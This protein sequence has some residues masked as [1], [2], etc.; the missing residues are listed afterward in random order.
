MT[1][2]YIH[3]IIILLRETALTIKMRNE[4]N[5]Q[6]HVPNPSSINGR[7]YPDHSM[8]DLN[9]E[10]ASE[11][12]FDPTFTTTTMNSEIM[13]IPWA[14]SFPI[15]DNRSRSQS[16]NHESEFGNNMAVA[17]ELALLSEIQIENEMRKK[18]QMEEEDADLAFALQQQIQYD[19]EFQS[20]RETQSVISNC[21][22][23][24]PRTENFIRTNHLGC[25][26]DIEISA[27]PFSSNSNA[28]EHTIYP[29]NNHLHN[30]NNQIN[31]DTD[32]AI[33]TNAD[34]VAA[35]PNRNNSILH[36]I[37]LADEEYARSL[38]RMEEERATQRLVRDQ[39]RL[40]ASRQ[41]HRSGYKSCISWFVAGAI[42]ISSI[43]TILYFFTPYLKGGPFDLFGGKDGPFNNSTNGGFGW[44]DDW[45]EG[46]PRKWNV[47][48][49]SSL[50]HNGKQRKGLELTILNAC[51]EDWDSYLTKAVDDW[52]LSASLDLNLKAVD[53][54]SSCVGVRGKIKVCNGDYGL[55][56]WVGV[57]E[58][59][60]E[61]GYIV[62]STA[63]M[64][65]RYMSSA[66]KAKK[67]YTMCHEIGHGLGLPHTDENFLNRD[68][69]N[70]LDY[71]NSPENNLEPGEVNFLT[72]L[73]MYGTVP[74]KISEYSTQQ[75]TSTQVVDVWIEGNIKLWKH[76]KNGLNLLVINALSPE[77]SRFFDDVLDDWNQAPAL[78][79]THISIPPDTNCSPVYESMKVCNGDYGPTEWL[80]INE[81]ILENDMI[82]MSTIKMNDFHLKEES[83]DKKQYS[84]CHEF[85]HGFGLTHTD[86][87]YSNPN[88]GNCLDYTND[89]KQNLLSGKLNW[90]RLEKL[91]G[92]P[93]DA[94]NRNKTDEVMK[95]D[96]SDRR[97]LRPWDKSNTLGLNS[98]P[99][100]EAHRWKVV[101]KNSIGETHVA[102]LSKGLQIVAHVTYSQ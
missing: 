4:Q 92:L 8:E 83:D 74:G 6:S 33:G 58:V 2:N 90:D 70:C 61:N 14:E 49:V 35:N 80:S 64:N 48:S 63:R 87:D 16:I 25:G 95:E 23:S 9:P 60:L 69:G 97:F 62:L 59:I 73:E 68:L 7:L 37:A 75:I 66:S 41:R 86:E 15:P 89:P 27:P 17:S 46:Q 67:Q 77:W 44:G 53:A 13:D 26:Y 18:K 40:S 51:T 50:I 101:K 39:Q 3:C 36:S 93:T 24:Y 28:H 71:T 54:E 99:L 78:A 55:T 38:N 91:Y 47:G 45:E 31:A 1:I 5:N 19:E 10:D 43:Y 32:T 76:G 100:V 94:K 30:L 21:P 57:N 34:F 88:L 65:E 12:T 72:L 102:N 85:G 42:G 52:N 22:P 84:L 11:Q 79:L 96:K 81:M 82:I 98:M 29:T 20:A 56:S